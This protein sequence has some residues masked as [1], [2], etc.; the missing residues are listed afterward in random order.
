MS[1]ISRIISQLIPSRETLPQKTGIGGRF[2]P[3]ESVPIGM[4]SMNVLDDPRIVAQL[5]ID[6]PLS[7]QHVREQV[8]EDFERLLEGI[9]KY[10]ISQVRYTGIRFRMIDEANRMRP[11]MRFFVNGEQ[12]FDMTHKLQPND[13]IFIV[14]ALSGGAD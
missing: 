12:T 11:H 4:P 14:Q 13:E 3:I 9:N 7:A 10:I 2:V 5:Q 6:N 8:M 1:D